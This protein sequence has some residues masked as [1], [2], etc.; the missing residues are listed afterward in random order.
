MNPFDMVNAINFTKEN[1]FEDP[2]A[3]KDYSPFLTNRALSYFPDT[4]FYA[5]E[6]NRL[7]HA[8][9]QWQFEFL[10]H[11]VPKRKRFSK[12]SK[13]SQLSDD[14]IAVSKYYKYSMEKAVEAMSLLSDEQITKIKQQMEQ[15]GKS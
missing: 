1:L 5:N 15:G 10:L 11:A 13:K 9:K 8:P 6:M 4:V 14:V 3:E 12:W 2:Q 7:S